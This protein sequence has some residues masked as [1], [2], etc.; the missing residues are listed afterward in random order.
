MG[1]ESDRARSGLVSGPWWGD[2]L[3]ELEGRGTR[4]AFW[5]AH[6][7]GFEG[8]K[9][10]WGVQGANSTLMQARDDEA[11]WGDGGDQEVWTAVTIVQMPVS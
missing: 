5:V 8:D 9:R 2:P 6:S 10:K 1:R 7:G 11:E 4:R 3:E